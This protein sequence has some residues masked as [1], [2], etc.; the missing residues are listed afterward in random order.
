MI[1]ITCIVSVALVIITTLLVSMR[2][3]TVALRPKNNFTKRHNQLLASY[4]FFEQQAASDYREDE[5]IK[6]I[7]R[8]KEIKILLENLD[9][10]EKNQ[11][12]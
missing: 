5:R 10:E 11:T 4:T 3:T 6:A 9:Q 12:K 1:A 7:S 2:I 8:M